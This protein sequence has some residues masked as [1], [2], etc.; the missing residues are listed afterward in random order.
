VDRR[1]PE[2]EAA[3]SLQGISCSRVRVIEPRME[4]T[5]ISLIRRRE[6]AGN[7]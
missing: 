7:V 4:E 5:F 2:I 3:L 1:K 6:A